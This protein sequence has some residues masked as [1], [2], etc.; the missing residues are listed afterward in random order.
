MAVPKQHKTKSSRNQRRMHI[1]LEQP[2]LAVCPKC[3]KPVLPHTV[4]LNCGSYKGKEVIN[5]MKKLTKKEKKKKEKE[6]A[7]KEK[8]EK[9][10]KPL[11]MEEL[12]K[13]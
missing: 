5:V 2:K 6:L 11:S 4:C 3:G 7:G 9:K 1:Y 10:E 13:K 12:S 8:E